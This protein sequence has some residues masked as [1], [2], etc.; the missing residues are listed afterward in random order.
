VVACGG[1]VAGGQCDVPRLG[2]QHLDPEAGLAG[3]RQPQQGD[4][5]VSPL[6]SPAVGSVQEAARISTRQPGRR[7]VKAAMICWVASLAAPAR[8]PTRSTRSAWLAA[9]LA[10]RSA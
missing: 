1:P 6:A 9:L 4:I 2:D 7:R 8:N 5:G 3:E 10:S